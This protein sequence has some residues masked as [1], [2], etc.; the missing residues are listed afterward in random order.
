MVAMRVGSTVLK[1]ELPTVVWTVVGKES[2][3]VDMKAGL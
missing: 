2:M 3:K 1:M